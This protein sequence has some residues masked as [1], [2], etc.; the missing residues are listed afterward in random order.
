VGSDLEPGEPF[1]C[2]LQHL[3]GQRLACALHDRHLWRT[4]AQRTDRHAG[5]EP[6]IDYGRT[7]CD[8]DVEFD[9]CDIVRRRRFCGEQHRRLDHGE[10]G[11]DVYLLDH[12]QRQ[13]R[14]DDSEYDGDSRHDHC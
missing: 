1:R 12:L 13:R 6:D 4:A 11:G 10:T 7:S 2:I 8:A 5:R 3:L 9:E 14:F